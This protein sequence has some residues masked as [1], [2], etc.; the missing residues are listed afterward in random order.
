VPG[1]ALLVF[2]GGGSLLAATALLR[3]RRNLGLVLSFSLGAMLCIFEVVEAAA[4][5]MRMWLQPFMFVVSLLLMGLA[6]AQRMR[7]R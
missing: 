7:A 1:I 5:G 6:L 4:I 2:I 3:K